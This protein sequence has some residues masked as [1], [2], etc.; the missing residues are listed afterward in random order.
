MSLT[1]P[2]FAILADLAEDNF[3][4]WEIWELV[5]SS[6][7]NVD[8]RQQLRAIAYQA[9]VDLLE[10]GWVRFYITDEPRGSQPE[11]LTKER[12]LSLMNEDV[13]WVIPSAREGGPYVHVEITDDGRERYFA[14]TGS[15]DSAANG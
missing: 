5:Y 10:D 4:L 8:D 12:A 3:G 6:L 15:N 11:V 14:T 7:G 9:L 2:Q 1:K 13:P